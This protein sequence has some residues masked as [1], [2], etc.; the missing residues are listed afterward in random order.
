MRNRRACQREKIQPIL[1]SLARFQWMTEDQ[2]K[3]KD[4]EGIH[5][6]QGAEFVKVDHI[7]AMLQHEEFEDEAKFEIL[8]PIVSKELSN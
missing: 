6:F 1:W 3:H 5:C 2:L 8:A 4:F 7:G